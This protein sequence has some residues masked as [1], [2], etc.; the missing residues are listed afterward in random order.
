[1]NFI[2][3]GINNEYS[4][5]IQNATEDCASYELSI[6]INGVL[7]EM[8]SAERK[9]LAND[10]RI[11]FE[12][13][14]T[15]N[16]TIASFTAKEMMEDTIIKWMQRVCSSFS[17][18]DL[19][20]NNY[21]GYPQKS[22]HLRVQHSE[23]LLL[24]AQQLKIIDEYIRSGGCNGMN[25]YTRPQLAIANQLSAAAYEKAIPEY[26]RKSFNASFEVKELELLRYTPEHGMRIINIFRLLPSSF[27]NHQNITSYAI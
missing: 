8:I 9:Y 10:A 26:S 11:R 21:G 20:F 7:G 22:I 3:F 25:I 16:L 6:R 24:M 2:L 13:D 5:G 12:E 18:F 27:I 23:P 14:S 19:S 15:P 17:S 4:Q 1:M